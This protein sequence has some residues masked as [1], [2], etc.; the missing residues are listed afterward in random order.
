ARVRQDP[1]LP[2]GDAQVGVLGGELVQGEDHAAGGDERVLA[3][4][5]GRGA[6]VSATAAHDDVAPVQPGHTGDHADV[7]PLRLEHRALLDVGFARAV[8]A[9]RP[10]AG[11]A[12]ADALERRAE[13]AALGVRAGEGAGQVV[14]SGVNGGAV[15]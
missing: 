15:H 2:D 6:R 7:D 1:Q 14:A 11:A 9:P 12:V 4:G 5:G 10:G 3:V 8:H 13:G